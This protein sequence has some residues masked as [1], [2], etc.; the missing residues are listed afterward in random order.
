MWST[1]IHWVS[2]YLVMS[3]TGPLRLSHPAVLLEAQL[4]LCTPVCAVSG[5]LAV[6]ESA[7]HARRP[8]LVPTRSRYFVTVAK[9]PVL[10]DRFVCRLCRGCIRR[11]YYVV[12]GEIL[13]PESQSQRC[14]GVHASIGVAYKQ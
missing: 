10:L 13:P 5:L 4:A 14:G 12:R 3:E 8:V 1:F 7:R 9:E 6:H 11:V 2:V